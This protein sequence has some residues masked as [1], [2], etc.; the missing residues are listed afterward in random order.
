MKKLVKH[1][2]IFILL[3]IFLYAFSDSYKSHNIDNLAYVVALGID[4]TDTDKI[5]VSFQFTE[6]SA[7]S[8]NGSSEGSG[9]VIDTVEANSIDAAV[10]LMN[11]YIGKEVNLAHCK[12]V[13]FSEAVAKNG[14]DSH[15]YS[16]INNSQLRP[17]SNIII[18]RCD[19]KYYI[20]NSSSNYETIITKYYDIFPNSANYTGYT[21]NVTVGDFFNEISSKTSGMVAILGGVNTDT[22]SNKNNEEGDFDILANESTIT[23]ER[24]TENIGL[25]V[26][27]GG[28][29]VGELT[30]I[31]SLCHS[32]IAD[33]VDTFFISI[34]DP[35]KPET[36]LD[37]AVSKYKKTKVAVDVSNGSPYINVEVSLN[38]RILSI[39]LGTDYINE[40]YLNRVSQSASNYLQS[41]MLEY[42]YKTS[43][44]FKACI[45]NFDKYA[46]SEFLT[47]PEWENYDW[48]SQYQNS[49]F[50]VDSS[51]NVNSSLLLTES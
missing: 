2:F 22:S 5:K 42:L 14:L 1:I 50:D 15:V 32:M 48:T 33:E 40:E 17:T 8:Q 23:G 12:V 47:I 39:D 25:A 18:S 10:N 46:V 11:A 49:F 4:N 26:F 51:V 7:F 43:T 27:K 21:S 36:N 13:V 28:T 19:A 45:D 44:E 41:R 31:E 29:L 24:G 6:S 3:I 38:A 20:E 9:T 35:N 34:P 16:L 37:L 30:A